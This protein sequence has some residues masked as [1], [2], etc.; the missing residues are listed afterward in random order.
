M[1]ELPSDRAEKHFTL[2]LERQAMV[3]RRRGIGQE[4]IDRQ[5]TAFAAAVRAV[6]WEH[7][8]FPQEGG[9]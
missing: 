1:L 3:M 5:L 2:S 6:V 7:V 4:A 9:R 8:M